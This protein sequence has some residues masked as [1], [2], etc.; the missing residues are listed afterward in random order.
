M[1]TDE[2]ARV[3]VVTG[4]SSGI[5]EA[6]ARALAAGGYR[7]A[8]LARRAERIAAL[9]EE[10]GE[11]ALAIE[12]SSGKAPPSVA[13]TSST[14]PRSPDALHGPATA[15]TPR[16]SGGSTDGPSH[17]ARNFSPTYASPSVARGI[18]PSTRSCC[19][20]LGRPEPANRTWVPATR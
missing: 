5:G 17:C 7:V 3:A 15:S 14:A 2:R 13:A 11:G 4:A 18:W 16:R 20:P 1:S 9:A 12:A 19:G 6:T 10:L 8:L